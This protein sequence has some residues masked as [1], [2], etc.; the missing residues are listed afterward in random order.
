MTEDNDDNK[1]PDSPPDTLG[2]LKEIRRLP[3]MSKHAP[4]IKWGD[5]YKT[6]SAK[7]QLK[8]AQDLASSM[9][10]AAD[11]LQTERDELLVVCGNQNE[12]ITQLQSSY[13]QQSQITEHEITNQGGE[14]QK[15]F[16]EI[17]QIKRENKA[18]K[19]RVKELEAP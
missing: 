12:L 4:K 2:E 11:I 6:W 9:N 16:E 5:V 17:V 3:A 18:L 7:K 10:H 8:Y 19:K 14:Q 15:L 1:Y 13:S